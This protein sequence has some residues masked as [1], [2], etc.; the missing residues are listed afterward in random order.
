MTRQGPLY[1]TR[2]RLLRHGDEVYR[3]R[4]WC[5][6]IYL[7]PCWMA[8]VSGMGVRRFLSANAVASLVWSL[9]IG[10]GSY[11]AGPSIADALGDV[12]TV[13]LVVLAALVVL[14]AFVR[15]R[16]RRRRRRP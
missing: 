14:S 15:G 12:G 9:T 11:V 10:L 2:L 7:A 4:S 3:R 5:L 8:G 13:G 1:E 6:A 16:R